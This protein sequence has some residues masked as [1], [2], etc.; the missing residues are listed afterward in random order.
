MPTCPPPTPS[1]SRPPASCASATAASRCSSAAPDGRRLVRVR[2]DDAHPISQGY[3][4][5]KPLAPRLLPERPAPADASRC[6]A[7]PT[8]RSRR[9]TGTRRSAR[10]PRASRR[11][12]T[13][14]AASRSSTTA[15]AARG[16]T[17][18]APTAARR[19]R[20]SARATGRARSRRRRPASSGSPT[21]MV[22][23]YSRGDFEH[24]EV[25][26]FIGKNPWFS[27]GIPR[28]RVTLRE[29]ANDPQ[30]C[31]IVIDPRRTET[32]E[33]A[34]IHLQVKPGRRRVPAR[35]A[36]RRARA[37]GARSRATGSPRTPTA[38]DEVLPHF[39][40]ARRR[41]A[42]ARSAACPRSWCAR[43]RGASP[44]RASVAT[45][46][47]LG[48][49]MNRHSTLVSYLHKL[50]VL[51]DRQLRQEGRR[52][53]PERRS[54]RS[55]RRAAAAAR[56]AHAGDGRAHHRRPD[57]VQ[58]RFPRRSSPTTRSASA[59]CSSRAATPRTRSPTARACA[60]RSRRSTWWW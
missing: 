54:C 5:E 41:R 35:G 21:K 47:D 24:C 50:L 9:S 16:I 45:F 51:L 42:T 19:A 26:L 40:D 33:L 7:A 43:P 23:G 49:Q 31:L 37:G 17:C 20:C 57:A 34:D 22:G 25:A 30:R 28:A 2:G 18:P 52:L 46:E 27:H 13:R 15:A 36:G 60:R 14:T 32:A 1:G 12:A 53:P 10:S 39:D 38:L 59:R 11:S 56:Q 4:C 3:A 44:R 29:I 8:A 6:A 55:R 48:V 58:R